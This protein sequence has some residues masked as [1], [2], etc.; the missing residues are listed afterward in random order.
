MSRGVQTFSLGIVTGVV[1]GTLGMVF[2][3]YGVVIVAVLVIGVTS[4]V[5]HMSGLSGG[6]LGLGASWLVF[7]AFSASACLQSSGNCGNDYTEIWLAI[8]L[9][10][11]IA[12][13]LV[14]GWALSRR[15]QA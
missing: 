10:A 11:V 2:G 13:T 7:T 15:R 5:L 3:W 12:G 1:A 14:G 4:S 9:A 8:A 6:L